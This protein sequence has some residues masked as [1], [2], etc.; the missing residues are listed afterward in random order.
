MSCSKRALPRAPQLASVHATNGADTGREA[1][2]RERQ[3]DGAA[4]E[5]A[6]STA[7]NSPRTRSRDPP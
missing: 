3:R 2:E 5:D 7:G 1:V 6:P 4:A